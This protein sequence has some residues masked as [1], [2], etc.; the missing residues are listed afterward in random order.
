MPLYIIERSFPEG[1][2]IPEGSTGANVCLKVVSNNSIDEVTWIHSFVS[3]DKKKSYCLYEAPSPE[4]IRKAAKRNGL[5]VDKI[6]EVSVL[7][8]YFYY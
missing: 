8:P 6:T 4:V 5:P 7:E 1:L 3:K 2:N